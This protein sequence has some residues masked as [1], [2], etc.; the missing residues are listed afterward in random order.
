MFTGN[1]SQFHI[2]LNEVKLL[3]LFGSGK[4]LKFKPMKTLKFQFED[5]GKIPNSVFPL[6]V[7]KQAFDPAENL[8]DVMERTFASN[9]WTNAWRNGVYTYHHFHSIAHEVVGVYKGSAQLHMGGENGE[10]LDV[11]AGDVLIIP[12]GTG[13]KQISASGDFAV[14]G[15]YPNGMDYDVLTGE[16]ANRNKIL[17]N[18]AKVPLPDNDP[19]LG[20]DEGIIKYWIYSG[21]ES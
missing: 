1:Y 10:K 5:D 13:H 18:L 9:N 17:D 3:S 16:E 20:N 11:E 12:A 14:L 6:I 8:D 2:S 15:A 21:N 4:G 7:Y 19:V